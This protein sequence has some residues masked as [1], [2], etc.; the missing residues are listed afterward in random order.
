M[1]HP[2]IKTRLNQNNEVVYYLQESGQ[3]LNNI[4]AITI[5]DYA[6]AVFTV[7]RDATGLYTRLPI[8]TVNTKM[9]LYDIIN[10]LGH[11]VR[12]VS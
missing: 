2:I 12:L 6:C 7:L 11:T 10:K 1:T 3:T 9:S 8:K 4:N 5:D